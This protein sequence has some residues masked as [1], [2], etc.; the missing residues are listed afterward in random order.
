MRKCVFYTP[1]GSDSE[2]FT[3][4]S[5]CDTGQGCKSA[6]VSSLCHSALSQGWRSNSS[7]WRLP[8]KN[9]VVWHKRIN[10]RS[11]PWCPPLSYDQLEHYCPAAGLCWV[12]QLPS[13]E[14]SSWHPSRHDS[15]ALAAKVQ[16]KGLWH[17]GLRVCAL[18]KHRTYCLFFFQES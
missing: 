11:N 17:V 9:L 3:V 7:P 1:M 15:V 18:T 10:H 8:W 12:S 16:L 2:Q 13:A 5:S 6:Q 4:P 14:N